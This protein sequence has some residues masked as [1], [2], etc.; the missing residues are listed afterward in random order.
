MDSKDKQT[1][2]TYH[3]GVDTIGGTN[4]EIAYG[5]AHI[6]FDLGVVYQPELALENEEYQTLLDNDLI[7]S[8]DDFYDE[9]LK[10]APKWKN[11]YQHSAAFVSHLHLDHTKMLNYIDEKMPI[12]TSMQTIE[13]L[14]V[15]N[16]KGTFLLPAANHPA[17]YMRQLTPLKMH[18][19]VHI[20]EISVEFYPID[21]DADGAV[22]MFIR[23]P[24]KLIVYTGDL[25]L[26][27]FHSEWTRK[28]MADAFECDLLICEGVGVS[29]LDEPHEDDD[30]AIESEQELLQ[31][32]K[33]LLKQNPNAPITFNT[34]PGN[35][36]RL[37]EICKIDLR[38]VVLTAKRA[39]LL[40]EI[41]GK[42]QPYY[43][44]PNE[45]PI[46]GLDSKLEIDYQE[47]LKDHGKYLWQV[48]NNFENLMPQT[49]YIHSDAEPL[50][51][52]D[53]AYQ[54]FLD[55]LAQNEIKFVRL[56]CSGH[57]T[58]AQLDEIIAA[59]KPRMLTPIHSFHPENLNNPFGKRVLMK[60]GQS[61]ILN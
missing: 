48:E 28:V 38:Q 15:L 58:A 20:G 2:V 31:R 50:G 46:E 12:Y 24:D 39:K 60:N 57:A 27:G 11:Q 21:H 37:E 55:M 1:I 25:R 52:F 30:S 8:L 18:Q 47:L 42:K 59:I 61:L 53:P 3:K 16:E 29:F 13:I 40:Q 43:Y 35:L 33:K 41:T 54:K 4:I 5:D 51:D 36:S 32:I 23:T 10:G 7:A 45:E 17:N 26:H 44:G 49:I 14:K 56:A 22:A 9:N 6:F 34:Y 19:K